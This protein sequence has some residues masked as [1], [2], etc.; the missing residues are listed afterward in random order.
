[1]RPSLGKGVPPAIMHMRRDAARGIYIKSL[2]HLRIA[3]GL[4][5]RNL[6]PNPVNMAIVSI[7]APQECLNPQLAL[8]LRN[9]FG[10]G[11]LRWLSP[12][13]AVEF[14]VEQIPAD[15]E[16]IRQDVTYEGA[17]LN[18]LPDTNRRKRLLLA[19]MDS[20]MIEQECIDELA[21]QAGIGVQVAQIT[22]RAMNGELDFNEALRDRVALLQGLPAQVITD[23]LH[24]RIT[25]APGGLTLVT[26]M[27]HGGAHAALVSGGFTAFSSEIAGRLRF[28]CHRANVL[29]VEND[30][31]TGRVVEPILGYDAKIE[32][33][34]TLCQDLGIARDDAIAVGDGA[35]DLGMLSAAGLGVALHAKPTVAAQSPIRI[36]HGD[37]TSLLFLQGYGREEF[38]HKL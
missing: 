2:R 26:T 37:L 25:L 12:D 17:D 8:S 18:I 1:M 32:R 33:L 27:R 35:N 5:R 36:S 7:I 23:V 19:D 24:T 3:S 11:D 29:E 4:R 9:A 22:L 34:D 16:A 21:D 38:R 28:N 6:R 15:F 10:G 13:E 20:T 30:V 31:L 14:P